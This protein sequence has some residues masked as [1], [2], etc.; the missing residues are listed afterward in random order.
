MALANE[1]DTV[2]TTP[3]VPGPV[4]I[5]RGDRHA[6]DEDLAAGIVARYSD[7]G[8]SETVKVR[9]IREGTERVRRVSP[10]EPDRVARLMI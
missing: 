2:L 4:G 8:S 1:S 6:D 7:A 5:L 3:E 10:L 9:A